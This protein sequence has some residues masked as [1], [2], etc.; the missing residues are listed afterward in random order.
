MKYNEETHACFKDRPLPSEINHRY[1]KK[2]V[3]QN[4][5]LMKNE[6]FAAA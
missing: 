3:A 1:E 4:Y 5:T 2:R 6:M